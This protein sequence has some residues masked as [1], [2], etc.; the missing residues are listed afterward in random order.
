MTS[1]K[2]G[3]RYEAREELKKIFSIDGYF[4]GTNHKVIELID[5]LVSRAEEGTR[6]EE[7]KRI[8]NGLQ[9]FF[10]QKHEK[11]ARIDEFHERC[12]LYIVNND[13]SDDAKTDLSAPSER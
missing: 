4:N 13:D 3:L 11:V 12:V 2:E 1:P 7:R 10:A 6:A 9:N 5:R 8:T